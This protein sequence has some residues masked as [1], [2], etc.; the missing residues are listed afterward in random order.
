MDENVIGMGGNL[1]SCAMPCHLSL[2]HSKFILLA[3]EEKL[4][5][6]MQQ[7]NNHFDEEKYIT[8]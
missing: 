2:L 8:I 1:T 3:V 4:K 5:F 6:L 7:F